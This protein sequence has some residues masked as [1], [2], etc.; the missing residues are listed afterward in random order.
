MPAASLMIRQVN[1][2]EAR[3]PTDSGCW[4]HAKAPSISTLIQLNFLSTRP[5]EAAERESCK[6]EVRVSLIDVRML[7]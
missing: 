5:E 1:S 4:L 6:A 3:D 2:E 7:T